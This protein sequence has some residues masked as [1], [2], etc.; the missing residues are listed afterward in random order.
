[1]PRKPTIDPALFDRLSK[2]LHL[3]NQVPEASDSDWQIFIEAIVK[4]MEPFSREDRKVVGNASIRANGPEFT[5]RTSAIRREYERTVRRKAD[6]RN[7]L[8]IPKEFVEFAVSLPIF[9]E[10]NLRKQID[11]RRGHAEELREV[12]KKQRLGSDFF[13]IDGRRYFEK[14]NGVLKEVASSP[15]SL[16]LSEG[17]PIDR[18]SIC[19]VPG[20]KKIYWRKQ[21]GEHKQSMT[22][23]KSCSEKYSK[24]NK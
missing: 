6:D 3:V 12:L 4:I 18:L 10:P 13:F 5:E 1:M 17:L 20:C 24:G 19:P 9:N 7:R 16:L 23:S 8:E 2:H 11:L 14:K 21:L 15:L 22:C